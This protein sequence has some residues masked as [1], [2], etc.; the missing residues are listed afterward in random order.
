MS[1]V[2]NF[3]VKRLI[4]YIPM[5]FVVIVINFLLINLAPGDPTYILTGE[6]GD[7]EF[8]KATRARLGLDRPI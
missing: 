2:L 5:M 7:E 6:I 1:K 8:I 3:I 4:Q